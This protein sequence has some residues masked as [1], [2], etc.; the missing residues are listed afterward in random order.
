MGK[1]FYVSPIGILQII[2]DGKNLTNINLVHEIGENC[3]DA[4]TAEVKRQLS[5][6]FDGKLK[7]FDLPLKFDTSGFNGAVLT[8]MNKIPYGGT[9]TYGALAEAAGSPKAYRYAGTCVGKNPIPIVMPC[10]RVVA[11]GGIGGF[12]WGLDIKRFLLNLEEKYSK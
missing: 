12:A 4:L 5:L 3:P 9:T 1:D 8:H 2:T 7:K 6:Y 11:K 10:H